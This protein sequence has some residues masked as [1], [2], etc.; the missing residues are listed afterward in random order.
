MYV[1]TYVRT[2]VCVYMCVYIYIYTYIHTYAHNTLCTRLPGGQ[3][4]ARE[5][6]GPPHHG[7]H[8]A[9]ILYIYIYILVY[10][11]YSMYYTITL[12]HNIT[13]VYHSTP[14]GTTTKGQCILQYII[15]CYHTSYYI[16]A[17]YAMLYYD[18]L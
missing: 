9:V 16:M 3:L 7:V 5:Q 4:P 6:L 17:Y 18:I 15:T 14:T 11:R 12:S 8:E 2:Y 1:C 10:T 13:G